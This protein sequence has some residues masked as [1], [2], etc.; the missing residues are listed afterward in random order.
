MAHSELAW[1]LVFPLENL[2]LFIFKRYFLLKNRFSC[3]LLILVS[4]NG[5]KPLHLTLLH[6]KFF[7]GAM[8]KNV[9]SENVSDD[10]TICSSFSAVAV[11]ADA[12]ALL[13]QKVTGCSFS[14]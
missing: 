1:T 3:F 14:F 2:D 13:F 7:P 9:A 4:G 12:H 6:R 11:A 5:V 10:C 8:K